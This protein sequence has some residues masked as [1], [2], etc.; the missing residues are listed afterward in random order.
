[1]WCI[2]DNGLQIRNQKLDPNLKQ[3][4]SPKSPQ[5]YQ[6]FG[7]R[8]YFCNKKI[9]LNIFILIF[10]KKEYKILCAKD[11]IYLNQHYLLVVLRKQI[12][13]LNLLC[14]YKVASLTVQCAFLIDHEVR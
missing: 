3:T 9:K 2:S 4:T 6:T 11:F 12:N 5:I 13:S 8:V 10:F 1:M 14:V 7:I